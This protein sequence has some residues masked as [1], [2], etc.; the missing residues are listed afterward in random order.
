MCFSQTNF[1]FMKEEKPEQFSSSIA[2]RHSIGS[3][4]NDKL[5]PD[6]GDYYDLS[7]QDVPLW[8]RK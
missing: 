8:T 6:I 4:D 1:H 5:F 2:Q 7:I 3:C